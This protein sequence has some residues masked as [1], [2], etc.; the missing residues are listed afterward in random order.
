MCSVFVFGGAFISVLWD[1]MAISTYWV[2]LEPDRSMAFTGTTLASPVTST[3]SYLGFTIREAVLRTLRVVA[4][5]T[6]NGPSRGTRLLLARARFA[7]I[8]TLVIPLWR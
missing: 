6:A 4:K 8:H 7:P 2:I 1:G 5:V 3:L